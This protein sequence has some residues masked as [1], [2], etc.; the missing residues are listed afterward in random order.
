MTPELDREVRQSLSLLA[1]TA[2]SM[3]A[4]LGIGLLVVRV[5]G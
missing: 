3:A 5:F 2:A 4:C 1:L